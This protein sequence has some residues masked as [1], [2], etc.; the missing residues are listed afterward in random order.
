M[1]NYCH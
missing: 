1:S